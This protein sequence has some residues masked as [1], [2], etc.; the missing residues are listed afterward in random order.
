MVEEIVEAKPF[1]FFLSHAREDKHEVARPLYHALKQRGLRVWFDE[2]ELLPGDNIYSRINSGLAQSHC[3]IVVFSPIFFEKFFTVNELDA[4]KAL[5]QTGT[6]IVPLLHNVDYKTAMKQYPLVSRN[7]AVDSKQPTEEIAEALRKRAERDWDHKPAYNLGEY[8]NTLH[9]PLQILP[10]SLR[11]IEALFLRSEWSDFGNTEDVSIPRTWMGSCNHNVIELAFNIFHPTLTY[12]QTKTILQRSFANYSDSDKLAY[13]LLRV[14]H[15]AYVSDDEFVH[16]YCPSVNYSPRVGGWRK[17][18]EE[19]PSKYLLQGLNDS[20]IGATVD[21]L[22]EES[23]TDIDNISIVE[24]QKM[25]EKAFREKRSGYKEIGLLF[26]PIYRFR[27]KDRPVFVRILCVWYLAYSCIFSVR[28]SDRAE[29]GL[30]ESELLSASEKLIGA[31]DHW[32]G[33]DIEN[34]ETAVEESAAYLKSQLPR[35]L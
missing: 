19:N 22:M 1:D 26:N 6:G 34:C 13:E 14:A 8:H 25:Y 3:G 12:H 2:I 28:K 33:E 10:V 20:E 32:A 24:F 29:Q 35:Y 16:Q 15:R 4:L 23:R 18:R 7:L 9:F 11:S 5:E 27:P 21:F 31:M 30:L 17:K